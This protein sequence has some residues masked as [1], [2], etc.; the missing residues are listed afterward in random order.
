MANE[1]L[2]NA[3]SFTESVASG[4][5]VL[6]TGEGKNLFSLYPALLDDLTEWLS[7]SKHRIPDQHILP[8]GFTISNMPWGDQSHP[9]RLDIAEGPVSGVFVI[10]ERVSNSPISQQYTNEMLQTAQVATDLSLDLDR[11]KVKLQQFL[12]ATNDICMVRFAEGD[13]PGWKQLGP[14]RIFQLHNLVFDYIQKKRTS[15]N[16]LWRNIYAHAL[17]SQMQ[18]HYK[19]FVLGKDGKTLTWVDPFVYAADTGRFNFYKQRVEG[20]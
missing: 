1:Q 15:G 3:G 10:K 2:E 14:N 19:D 16:V 18:P 4:Q 9:H 11:L 17:D 12:F 13:S 8:A 7:E 5:R 20:N 6:M